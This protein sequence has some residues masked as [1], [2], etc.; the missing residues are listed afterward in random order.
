MV[1]I[2]SKTARLGNGYKLNSSDN[3]A[4]D[5]TNLYTTGCWS[6]DLYRGIEVYYHPRGRS[7]NHCRDNDNCAARGSLT[8]IYSPLHHYNVG[9]I[10]IEITNV[11][12]WTLNFEGRN[13]QHKI[14]RSDPRCGKF[15]REKL[16][17]AR[18]IDGNYYDYYRL[19]RVILISLMMSRQ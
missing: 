5:S 1:G 17:F 8:L 11:V 18:F 15:S 9:Y 10:A 19:L 7:L 14:T 2:T 13:C 12:A 6:N 4:A 3:I 16:K